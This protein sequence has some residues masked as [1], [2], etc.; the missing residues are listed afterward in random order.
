MAT[1]ESVK[2]PEGTVA[3]VR[4]ISLDPREAGWKKKKKKQYPLN[5][6][7]GDESHQPTSI[8]RIQLLISAP[9]SGGFSAE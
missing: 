2:L 4:D 5:M 8:I 1:T 9:E 6:G 7:A 3:D